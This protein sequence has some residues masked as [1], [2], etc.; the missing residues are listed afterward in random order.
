AIVKVFVGAPLGFTAS[1]CAGCSAHARARKKFSP[2]ITPTVAISRRQVHSTV[3][4]T[5]LIIS[6]KRRLIR[7]TGTSAICGRQSTQTIQDKQLMKTLSNISYSVIALFGFA[8]FAL[9]PEARAFT[10]QEGCIGVGNTDTALGW[11]ALVN[12]EL[13]QDN[14]AIGYNAM[15]TSVNGQS[16]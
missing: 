3:P 13:G 14:T 2:A 10:C 5:R 6:T 1:V 8:C 9:A 11:D 15:F 4:R 12:V 16:N 7:R